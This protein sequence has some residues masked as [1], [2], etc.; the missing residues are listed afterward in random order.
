MNKSEARVEHY[1]LDA[2]RES[3]QSECNL[4]R[5]MPVTIKLVVLYPQ[6]IDEE[7][8]EQ[9]YHGQHMPLMRR[10][11][12]PAERTP[13][14]RVRLPA[15]APF[16]RMAEVH[17]DC[18]AELEAFATSEAGKGARHSSSAVSTGGKP[19]VLVCER[20]PQ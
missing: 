17:F 14:Y 4:K 18:L 16:Y 15:D 7:V 19:L 3:A 13:T 8:F 1:A 10:L 20:D 9:I 11:I 12:T 6:P 5:S 2:P